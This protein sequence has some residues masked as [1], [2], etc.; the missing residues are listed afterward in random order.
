MSSKNIVDQQKYTILKDIC[1]NIT[2]NYIYYLKMPIS[3]WT[4]EGETTFLTE[5]T[6]A[7][8]AANEISVSF[9]LPHFS[10]HIVI[11]T[12]KGDIET[13]KLEIV[14]TAIKNTFTQEIA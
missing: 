5:I 1:D 11:T 4:G 10:D 3:N 7:T 8:I 12:I 2:N 9:F 13:H 14:M 6:N